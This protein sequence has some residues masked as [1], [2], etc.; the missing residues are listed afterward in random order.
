MVQ[1]KISINNEEGCINC[2]DF[3]TSQCEKKCIFT[4]RGLACD[5]KL[6]GKESENDE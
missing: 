3:C 1:C 2:C 5:N 6:I 4:K